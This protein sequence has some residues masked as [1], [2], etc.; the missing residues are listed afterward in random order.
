MIEAAGAGMDLV[1]SFVSFV[2]GAEVE[3]LTL[4]GSADINGTGNDLD[5]ALRGNSGRNRLSGSDGDDRIK[6]G[7]GNDRLNG[8]DGSDIYV[9][10]DR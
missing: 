5:N 10:G 2:L 9:F 6:G 1:T 3:N 4:A 8:G 7:E